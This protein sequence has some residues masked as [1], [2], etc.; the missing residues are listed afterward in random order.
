MRMQ[1][2]PRRGVTLVEILVVMALIAVLAA[3]AAAALFRVRAAQSVSASNATIQKLNTA[4]D[5]KWRAVVDDAAKDARDGRIP[6]FILDFAANDR[7]RAQTIWT[8]LKLKNEFPTTF[9]EAR[10]NVTLNNQ[11]VLPAKQAIV[12][13]LPTADTGWTPEQQSAACLYLVL[14]T[15][16]TRGETF[17]LDGMNQQITELAST[18]VSIPL[19]A[20]A[21]TWGNPIVFVR[22][23]YSQ[24]LN[25]AP[26]ARDGAARNVL[27]AD[28]MTRVSI[29]PRD[30]LDPQAKLPTTIN[31]N[32][33]VW[34]AQRLTRFWLDATSNH[35]RY[36]W[37]PAGN[38]QNFPDANEFVRVNGAPGGYPF[39]VTNQTLVPWN[40]M[41]TLLSAGENKSYSAG[42]PAALLGG[43]DGGNDNLLGYRLKREGSQG[44]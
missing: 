17:D 37:S 14:T 35:I 25:N 28:G 44:N 20:F 36:R 27:L 43:D 31:M 11:V 8:Y 39:D 22:M 5:R 12:K 23:A 4:I 2:A 38:A 10:A 29:V 1:R 21:D 26:Y 34:D 30:P 33:S 19:S 40:W 13:Q 9:A 32:G 18:P 15:S 41:P 42:T 7:D 3:I 24:E 6:S 16:G